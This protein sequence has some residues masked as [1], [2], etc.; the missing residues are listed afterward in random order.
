MNLKM[1]VMKEKKMKV[2]RTNYH[3]KFKGVIRKE[4]LYQEF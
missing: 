2:R 4:K 1:K 3:Y